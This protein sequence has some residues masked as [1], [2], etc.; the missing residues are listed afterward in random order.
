VFFHA[1]EAVKMKTNV[2]NGEKSWIKAVAVF[3]SIPDCDSCGSGRRA[4]RSCAQSRR[5][6]LGGQQPERE[7][8]QN[9]NVLL[10][11]YRS[12]QQIDGAE[13]KVE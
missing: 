4:I 11:K 12:I 8:I 13:K 1:V 10:L 7:V 9:I 5:G 3:G 2:I 6:L